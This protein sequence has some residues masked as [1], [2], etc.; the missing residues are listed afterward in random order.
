MFSGVVSRARVSFSLLLS[1][2]KFGDPT[3]YKPSGGPASALLTGVSDYGL[4]DV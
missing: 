1:S 3:V 4:L 2:L